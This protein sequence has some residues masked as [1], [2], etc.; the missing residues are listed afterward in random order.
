MAS[1]STFGKKKSMI[2]GFTFIS[3]KLLTLIGTRTSY[4]RSKEIQRNLC[5]NTELNYSEIM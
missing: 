1:T 3:V 5:L 4:F 2:A